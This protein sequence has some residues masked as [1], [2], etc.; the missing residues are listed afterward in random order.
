MEQL[1]RIASL[2]GDASRMKMLW[3][4]L[5]GRAYTATELSI[6]A[7]ASRQST[8]MHLSKLVDA[9]LLKV[10]SQGRHKYY[11][12]ARQEIAYAIEAMSVLM[13]PPTQ[14]SP[15]KPQP[16]KYC[17]TCYDH[18]AGSIGVK[19]LDRLVERHYLIL[20]DDTPAITETGKK[21]FHDLGI[22]TMELLSL[23]RP[24]AR[25]CLDWSERRFHLA[26]SLG[27]VLLKKLLEEDWVRRVANSRALVIT[28]KGKQCFLE[29]LGLA[30]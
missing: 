12:F 20:E 19:L 17:R 16:I 1:E 7:D 22:D 26:G 21:F 3:S 24:F 29:V 8:S 5:D 23:K 9:G 4:L 27:N 13:P 30:V 14:V 11:S 6:V 28:A 18:M 25:A 15:V 2:I 10:N